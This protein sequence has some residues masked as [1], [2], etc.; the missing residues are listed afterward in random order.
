MLLEM[1]RLMYEKGI[2]CSPYLTEDVIDLWTGL[3]LFGFA[4]FL[5]SG[6][7]LLKKKKTK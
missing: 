3:M 5:L 2:D 1:D 6:V 7:L 4:A